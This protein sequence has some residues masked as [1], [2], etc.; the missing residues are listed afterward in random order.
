MRKTITIL[1]AAFLLGCL[2]ATLF[3]MKV[4]T[5]PRIKFPSGKGDNQAS[6]VKAI[7]VGPNGEIYIGSARNNRVQV[8]S[9][10]GQFLRSIPSAK[11]DDIEVPQDIDIG[12]DGS[13]Y[14]VDRERGELSRFG[15]DGIRQG[16]LGGKK[17]FKKPMSV[18][19][20]RDG[21]VYVADR[22]ARTVAILDP[23][24]QSLGSLQGSGFTEPIAVDV[25]HQGCVFV[26]DRKK[27][28]VQIFQNDHSLWAELPV[29]F[30]G[31]EIQDPVDL[32][33][34]QH[35]EIFVLDA[36]QKVVYFLADLTERKWLAPFGGAGMFETPISIDVSGRDICYVLDNANETAWKFQLKELPPLVKGAG[37]VE[38]IIDRAAISTNIDS[39]PNIRVHNLDAKN[40]Q[41]VLSVFENNHNIASGLIAENF[42]KASVGGQPV[43]IMSATP[44]F[45]QTNLDF[46]FL[47]GT[48]GLKDKE[49][50]LIRQKIVTEFLSKLDENKHRVAVI[51]FADEIKVALPLEKSF[52]KQKAVISK[53]A[54]NGQKAPLFDAIFESF[55]YYDTLQTKNYPI[56]I[57]LTNSDGAG[58]RNSYQTLEEYKSS[59][60]F[61]QIHVLAYDNRKSGEMI[62]VLTKLANLSGGFFY[63]SDMA[64][65][66]YSILRR[67]IAL[68][69]GEY[70]IAVDNLPPEGE[71]SISADVDMDGNLITASYAYSEP[72]GEKVAVKGK[73]F[74]EKYGLLILII[75]LILILLIIII[76]LIRR[77]RARSRAPI[78]EALLELK[79]GNAPQRVYRLRKGINR[80]GAE[81]GCDIHISQEGISRQHAT[82]E[83]AGGKYEL[84]DQ[85]STNGTYVNRNRIARRVLINNDVISIASAVEFIFKSG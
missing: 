33:V 41:I 9:P 39:L 82:I 29:S 2:T 30:G 83:Y 79:S 72:T 1:L 57:V 49:L 5:L 13:I 68:I 4:E 8:F 7:Y 10:N 78:G 55:K 53:L 71:L 42:P 22:D 12:I 27:R 65:M 26:L 31:Q 75:L 84:V 15:A 64:D 63:S 17:A 37:V 25:D 66:L 20:S 18:S 34:N 38:T 74:F 16:T 47:L 23:S 59:H 58:S 24:G 46:I 44:L 80:I 19:V 48:I 43:R 6:N 35:G 28:S 3:S 51:T 11:K 54:F 36:G 45:S 70:L 62:E 14:V 32:C 56:I 76:V 61:P 21:T 85:G 40:R 50:E 69:R 67:A 52:S 60:G 77:A 73:G 81:K